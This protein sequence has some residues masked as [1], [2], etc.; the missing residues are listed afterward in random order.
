MSIMMPA[1]GPSEVPLLVVA[2]A[3]EN[4]TV[5]KSAKGTNEEPSSKSSTIHSA[6]SRHNALLLVSDLVT[7]WPVVVFSITALPFLVLDAVTVVVMTSPAEM[8]IPLKS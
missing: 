1:D 6:F 2:V 4:L 3:L 8:S 7:V 5:P